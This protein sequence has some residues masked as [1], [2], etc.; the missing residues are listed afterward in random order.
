MRKIV[1]KIFHWIW[2]LD[3]RRSICKVYPFVFII[4]DLCVCGVIFI[5]YADGNLYKLCRFY[6]NRKEWFRRTR[7]VNE[8]I[9]CILWSTIHEKLLYF[10]LKSSRRD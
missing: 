6:Y 1:E 5:T 4:R 10:N 3:E 2:N 7:R 8:L 9:D